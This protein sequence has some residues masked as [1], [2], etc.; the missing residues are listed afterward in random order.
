MP[1]DAVAQIVGTA[2]GIDQRAVLALGHRIDGQV[3][4]AQIILQGDIGRGIDGETLVAA[5]AF[6]LGARKR[7]LLF[8]L[9]MEKNREIRADGLIALRNH[10]LWRG[11]H[12]H[13]VAVLELKT[14]QLVTHRTSD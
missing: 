14:E 8:R 1:Q 7:I 4:P 11:A 12:Y 6:A 3:T 9:G 2:E 13:I 5:T 10:L